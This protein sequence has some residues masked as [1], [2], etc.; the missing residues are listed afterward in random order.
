M[1]KPTS[2]TRF[3]ATAR[4]DMECILALIERE[5]TYVTRRLS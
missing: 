1:A 2:F 4:N 5:G 3:L